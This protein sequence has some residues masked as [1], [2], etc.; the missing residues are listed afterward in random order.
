MIFLGEPN[1]IQT[2]NT[3]NSEVCLGDWD[4]WDGYNWDGCNRDLIAVCNF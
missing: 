3:N 1:T 4:D 2:L